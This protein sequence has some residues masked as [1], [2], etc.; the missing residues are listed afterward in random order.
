MREN[1]VQLMCIP[2][3]LLNQLTNSRKI[4]E[5]YCTG[6]NNMADTRTCEIRMTLPQLI[7]RHETVYGSKEQH[8][9]C[10]ALTSRKES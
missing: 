4:Y 5:R 9:K 3:Q 7:M 6:N 1:C 8:K 2:F 10:V